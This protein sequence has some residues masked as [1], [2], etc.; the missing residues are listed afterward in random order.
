MNVSIFKPP[1]TV[2]PATQ[3]DRRNL[4]NLIHFET[5]V[6]RH[7]DWRGPLD[8]L[9]F[10]PY[11]V[12]EQRG[13]IIAALACPPDPDKVAWIRLF[14]VNQGFAVKQAWEMLWPDVLIILRETQDIERVAALPLQPW[15]A[16]LLQ[17]FAF[18]ESDQ[19]V[20]LNC[21]LDNLQLKP[22][23]RE[24]M[25]RLMNYDDIPEVARIDHAAFEPIWR[26]S[27]GSLQLAYSQASLATV[28]EIEGE[29][30]GYQISTA[31]PV[32]GHLSRLAVLPEN[33]NRS[34]GYSLLSDLLL[35]FKAR[36]AL[37]IT[38]NTQ[39]TNSTSLHLYQKAGFRL[40]GE[41]YPVYIYPIL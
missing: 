11:L 3:D 36:G 41:Q 30:V 7:L 8:W 20:M 9:G 16:E 6:H 28:A 27:L 39:K 10:A 21:N 15:F 13:K 17:D 34:I 14:A 4:A 22:A 31:T 19:V 37:R 5:Q 29:I 1:L 26:N 38:V 40:T 23:I 2:R 32:G 33:Q 24:A 18:S 35:H 12:L 25:V